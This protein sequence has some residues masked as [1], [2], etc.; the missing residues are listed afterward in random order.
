MTR[1][2]LVISVKSMVNF[3][4]LKKSYLETLNQ[5]LNKILSRHSRQFLITKILDVPWFL[6]SDSYLGA[7]SVNCFLH[8][9]DIFCPMLHSSRILNDI[10][11]IFKISTFLIQLHFVES[12]NTRSKYKYHTVFVLQRTS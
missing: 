9:S 10:T 5:Y 11:V 2:C 7:E 4:P 12:N 8:S 1:S 6:S 3:V